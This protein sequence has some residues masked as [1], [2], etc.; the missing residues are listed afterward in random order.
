VLNRAAE[1]GNR[2]DFYVASL[3]DVAGKRRGRL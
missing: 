3:I 1:T 2:I